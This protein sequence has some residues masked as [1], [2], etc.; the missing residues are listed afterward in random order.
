MDVSSKDL[1]LEQK[2]VQEQRE[3]T[4]IIPLIREY[5][6]NADPKDLFIV[7]KFYF[8]GKPFPDDTAS[9]VFTLFCDQVKRKLKVGTN[10]AIRKRLTRMARIGIL[11]KL[12][13][14]PTV[15]APVDDGNLIAAI[16][17]LIKRSYADFK[18]STDNVFKPL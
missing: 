11:L 12:G 9:F 14:S 6:D 16:R 15:Y 1:I 13:A 10:E 4:L 18:E 3:E 2:P 8:T 5:F 17:E 7:S